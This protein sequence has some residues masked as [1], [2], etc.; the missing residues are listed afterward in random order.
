MMTFAQIRRA[1]TALLATATAVTLSACGASTGTSNDD[2]VIG[3][4]GPYTGTYSSTY[5]AVPQVLSAWEQTINAAGGI[6]GKHVKVITKDIGTTTGAANAA[7]RELID[8]DHVVAVVA[9]QDAG[10]TAWQPYAAS[11][12]V[13]ILS[14]TT[15]TG[16]YIDGNNF[17]AQG[18][19]FAV[20]YGLGEQAKAA[21]GKLGMAYCA[22]QPSCAQQAQL[23]QIFVK[24]Q[25]V[26][27]PVAAKVPAT[28]ADFTAFCQQF[29]TAGVSAIF[30]SLSNELAQRMNDTCAQQGVQAKQIISGAL[31]NLQ[32]KT[33]PVYR[34]SV[35]LDVVAPFF[36]TSVPGV[37][38]YRQ[39]LEKYGSAMTGTEQDNSMALRAWASAQL[40]AAAAKTAPGAVTSDAIKQGLYRLKGQTLDGIVPPIV[41][42]PEK[43][44]SA[45]CYF[46]WSPFGQ[47]QSLD[48]A[49]PTCI[50]AA[51]IDPLIAPVLQQMT[52]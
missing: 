21:G 22:E 19:A 29:A 28:T 4:L 23:L 45:Q 50:P 42:T 46:R 2:I 6:N 7:V 12:G 15:E 13:P 31:T 5:G 27:I 32:W 17:N 25:S 47:F 33:D 10:D 40:F 8:R 14:A 11:K 51:T 3:S 24:A 1:G 34:D 41:F 26:Q 37:H 16:S 43:P 30:N 36:D 18:S 38:A 52:K 9:N 49:K 39:A 44:A 20:V 48:G 35:V